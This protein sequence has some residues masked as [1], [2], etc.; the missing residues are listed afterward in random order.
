VE[1]PLTADCGVL[2][3]K[4]ANTSNT[5][6]ITLFG[7]YA[8]FAG[9]KITRYT[10]ISS[11]N[12]KN[13]CI[14]SSVAGNNI[15]VTI[16]ELA[17]GDIIKR[18][19]ILES[20][21]D[22][23]DFGAV[24]DGRIDCSPA[25]QACLDLGGNIV[26]NGRGTCLLDSSVYIKKSNT[27]LTIGGGISIVRGS[28]VSGA[29]IKNEASTYYYDDERVNSNILDKI[30]IEGGTIN[31]ANRGSLAIFLCDISNFELRNI[32]IKNS[33]AFGLLFAN[34]YGFNID[35]VVFDYSNPTVGT[36]GMHFRGDL[37][38]GVI[39]HIYGNT[40][41]D[42]VSLTPTGDYGTGGKDTRRGILDNVVVRDLFGKDSMCAVKLNT[43]NDTPMK[44]IVIDGIYGHYTYN[45]ISI[46]NWMES[47]VFEDILIKDIHCTCDNQTNMSFEGFIRIA[48]WKSGNTTVIENLSI[49][50][51]YIK[52]THS[53]N[54]IRNVGHTINNL[55]LSNIIIDAD[56]IN[57]SS[58]SILN[59]GTINRLIA[60]NVL[61]KA[62]ATASKFNKFFNC[63][64][65]PKALLSNCD[66]Y[67]ANLGSVDALYTSNTLV[68]DNAI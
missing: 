47:A 4:D 58:R 6:E 42:L 22:P 30:V 14:W 26:I 40:G 17:K 19:D 45:P 32:K 28:N 2:L 34:V 35:N 51:S 43:G 63:S 5:G 18:L 3:K 13:L 29:L 1:N 50:D 10:P 60:N 24:Y 37:K 52:V 31:L 8:G 7:L 65:M 21:L 9:T 16:E 27:H 41:D 33:T 38:D 67:V 46:G 48:D 55:M 11:K 56:D 59:G 36:D 44:K 54:I 25:L 39:H 57:L 12:Y 53:M 23:Q 66:L 68:N 62:P 64:T 49:V 20:N 15:N 61:V